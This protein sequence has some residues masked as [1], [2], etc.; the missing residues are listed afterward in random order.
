[1]RVIIIIN[2]IK[3]RKSFIV[4]QNFHPCHNNV[5]DAC[6]HLKLFPVQSCFYKIH[7]RFH[8][9]ATRRLVGIIDPKLQYW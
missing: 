3:K 6:T 2:R 8:Q 5:P 9:F 7:V 4:D 1:M